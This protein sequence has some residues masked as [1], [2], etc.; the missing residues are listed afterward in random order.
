MRQEVA[1]SV[2]SGQENLAELGTTEKRVQVGEVT[3]QLSGSRVF[4][5]EGRACRGW[6]S[7]PV[8]QE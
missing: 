4:Q 8:L 6:G 3:M 2:G 7:V 1:A 5:T